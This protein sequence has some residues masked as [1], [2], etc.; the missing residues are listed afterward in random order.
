MDGATGKDEKGLEKTTKSKR[1]E[2]Q[3]TMGRGV[4]ITDGDKYLGEGAILLG[5]VARG[6]AEWG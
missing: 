4:E 2:V 6:Q 3:G 1:A 5:I